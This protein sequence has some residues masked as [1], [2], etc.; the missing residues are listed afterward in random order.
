VPAGSPGH[1]KAFSVIP[2][3]LFLPPAFCCEIFFLCDEVRFFFCRLHIFITGFLN[4]VLILTGIFPFSTKK[5]A[6]VYFPL[7]IIP[8]DKNKG[9]G[10]NPPQFFLDKNSLSI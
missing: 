10:A 4:F 1:C 9:V 6:P 2:F 5:K 8:A 3:M 7:S